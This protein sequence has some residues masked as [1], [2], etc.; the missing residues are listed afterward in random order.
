LS[1]VSP[2]TVLVRH[3]RRPDV[4]ATFGDDGRLTVLRTTIS[5]PENNSDIVYEVRVGGSISG[6]GISWPRTIR[7]THDDKPVLELELTGLSVGTSK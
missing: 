5:H 6:G 3:P 4:E 1:V 7:I 2:R